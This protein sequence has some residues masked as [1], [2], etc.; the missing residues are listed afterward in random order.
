MSLRQ[1]FQQQVKKSDWWQPDDKILVAVSG[2]VDSI[3]LLHLL[4]ELPEEVKPKIYVAHINHQLR[5]DSEEEEAYVL[6]FCRDKQV[7]IHTTKWSKGPQITSNVEQ[8]ARDFRYTFFE[9]VMKKER[10]QTLVTAHHAD[11]QVETVMMRL[12]SGNRLSTLSG[13]KE[14]RDLN[15]GN[16]IRPLLHMK[17]EELLAYSKERKLFFYEDESNFSLDYFRNRLRQ[18]LIPEIKKENPKFS[19]HIVHFSQELTNDM[20]LLQELMEPK[21]QKCVVFSKAGWK[22]N[23]QEFLACTTREQRFILDYFIAELMKN[24]TISLGFSQKNQLLSNLLSDKPNQSYHLKNGWYF[25]RTYDE[26]IISKEVVVKGKSESFKVLKNTGLFLSETEWFGFFEKAHEVLPERCQSWE[27]K[28]ISFVEPTCQ[29]VVI[30][31]H[32]AGDRLIL[33]EK[34]HTKKVSRYFIDEKIPA[35][36]REKSWVVE[37][38]ENIVKW[39]VPFRESYLSIRDETDKIQ[40]KLVYCYKD[41]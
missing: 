14:K 5:E 22:I 12:I 10:I 38:H 36:E 34:K 24:E 2:G 13:I 1:K 18:T 6:K 16:V 31:R 11:D 33:N 8:E 30:R 39:L 15:Y 41:K 32:R 26:V 23:R 19:E 25:K 40:Y 27:K 7:P 9:E 28:S 20:T 35:L 29:Q 3:V 21:Y 4:L 17:K 37:D